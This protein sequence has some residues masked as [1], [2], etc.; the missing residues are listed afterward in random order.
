MCSQRVSKASTSHFY[1]AEDLTIT[2]GTATYGFQGGKSECSRTCQFLQINNGVD[3]FVEFN[4]YVNKDGYYD[5]RSLLL[6][7]MGHMSY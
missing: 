4:I 5:I 1:E 2:N 3:D 6:F 7:F